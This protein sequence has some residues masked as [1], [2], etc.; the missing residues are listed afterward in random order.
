M[1]KNFKNNVLKTR[2]DF[3]K[4]IKQQENNNELIIGIDLSTSSTGIAIINKNKEIIF[5]DNLEKVGNIRNNNLIDFYISINI[6]L[7]KFKPKLAI[8]EDVFYGLNF[9]A[10][11]A[12]LKYHGILELILINKN[13]DYYYTQTNICKAFFKCKHKEEIFELL[14]KKYNLNF[15]FEKDNDKTDALMLA[16]NFENEKVI[17][18]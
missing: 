10:V 17:K 12:L 13:I 2:K 7:N 14:N 5:I 18:K 6:I 15:N 9:K 1:N 8:I 11:S 16:L 3:L 4:K